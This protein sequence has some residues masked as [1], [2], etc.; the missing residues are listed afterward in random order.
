MG[1]RHKPPIDSYL[2]C[3]HQ[4]VFF[5]DAAA[6][7]ALPR[8]LP[9][10]QSLLVPSTR[11]TSPGRNLSPVRQMVPT[12]SQRTWPG[13]ESLPLVNLVNVSR[14]SPFFICNSTI[15]QLF[16]YGHVQSKTVKNYQRLSPSHLYPQMN[17][18]CNPWCWY[19]K[20]Y[21]GD[22]GQGQMFVNIPAPWSIWVIGYDW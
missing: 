3:Y 20:T 15:N 18:T 17:P 8:H 14:K 2:I 10:S 21:L 4:D 9:M 16:H 7:N 19:I 1:H 22:V 12:L 6:A 13:C 5:G 11:S